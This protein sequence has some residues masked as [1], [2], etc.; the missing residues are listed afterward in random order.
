MDILKETGALQKGAGE[1]RPG[2][3]M[4]NS[5]DSGNTTSTVLQY[6]VVMKHALSSSTMSQ[7]LKCHSAQS[8]LLM[9]LWLLAALRLILRE[10]KAS[11]A[12]AKWLLDKALRKKC[13][14]QGPS[15]NKR[16]KI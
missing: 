7:L 16:T 11:L 5:H 13:H 15:T 4:K 12:K 8:K 1:P 10:L 6:L 14:L 3:M 2:R 9:L